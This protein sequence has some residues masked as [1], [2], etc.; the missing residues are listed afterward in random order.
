M[1]DP[2]SVWGHSDTQQSGVREQRVEVKLPADIR[3]NVENAGLLCKGYACS[4]CANVK[5]K[6]QKAVIVVTK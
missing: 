3:K 1:K 5:N 6:S 2:N 4:P